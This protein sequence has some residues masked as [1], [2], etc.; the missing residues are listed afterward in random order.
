MHLT[1]FPQHLRFRPRPPDDGPRPPGL[2]FMAVLVAALAVFALVLPHPVVLP[3]FSLWSLMAAA[4][5]AFLAILPLRARTSYEGA[6][7]DMA[8]A[9]TL[10]GCAAAILGEIEPI[11]EIIRPSGPRSKVND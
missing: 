3:V 5:A 6:A 4:C 10:V 1:G 8:G 9:F 7:W 11:V 2:A